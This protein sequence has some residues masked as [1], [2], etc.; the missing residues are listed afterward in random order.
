M[1]SLERKRAKEKM[2]NSKR[3]KVSF[4]GQVKCKLREMGH[5]HNFGDGNE[6]T[7]MGLGWEK[8]WLKQR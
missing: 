1:G 5:R 6:V 2:S 7:L 3:R 8:M 4:E